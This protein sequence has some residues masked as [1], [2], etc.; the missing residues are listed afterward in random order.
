MQ[1]QTFAGHQCGV[2]ENKSGCEKLILMP[3]ALL[4]KT[5]LFKLLN[6]YED[7]TPVNMTKY[8]GYYM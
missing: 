3:T 5:T 7:K 6:A 4:D 2:E 1:P 8:L